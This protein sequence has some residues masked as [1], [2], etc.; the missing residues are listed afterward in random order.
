MKRETTG[1]AK[2]RNM[3]ET[4]V[5]G[6]QREGGERWA[7]ALFLYFPKPFGLFDILI[8]HMSHSGKV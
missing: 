8:M 1:R 5:Y 4:V 2:N 6:K 3:L 7:R